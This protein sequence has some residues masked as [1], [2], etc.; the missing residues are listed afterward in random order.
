MCAARGAGRG[1]GG[2][3][4]GAFSGGHRGQTT[5]CQ[6]PY[7]RSQHKD[8]H[9]AGLRPD[10]S[11]PFAVPPF[12]E[13]VHVAPCSLACRLDREVALCC[14]ALVLSGGRMLGVAVN[15]CARPARSTGLLPLGLRELVQVGRPLAG[16]HGQALL[17]E[18]K[19]CSETLAQRRFKSSVYAE[20]TLLEYVYP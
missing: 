20:G 18:E 16:A 14:L 3:G 15:V 13:R 1:G 9:G 2:N 7:G 8:R 10:A 12:L 17:S 4:A 6:G 5:R 19:T 11:E